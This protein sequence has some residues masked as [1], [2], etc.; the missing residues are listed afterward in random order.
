V[1]LPPPA[2]ARGLA[3]AAEIK[4]E[5]SARPTQVAS[6]QASQPV[7]PPPAD[8]AVTPAPPPEDRIEILGMKLPNGSDLRNAV[9]SIGEALNLPKAF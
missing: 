3:G 1:P 5:R 6:R 9:S 2:P 8:A 7:T 4:P